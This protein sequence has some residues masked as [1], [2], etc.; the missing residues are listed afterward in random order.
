M[1]EFN[2]E[3]TQ[4]EKIDINFLLQMGLIKPIVPNQNQ[5]TNLDPKP[6]SNLDVIHTT[7][8]ENEKKEFSTLD[9]LKKETDQKRLKVLNNEISTI[10]LHPKNTNDQPKTVPIV[11]VSNKKFVPNTNQR[12]QNFEQ[13]TTSQLDLPSQKP[14]HI[15]RKTVPTLEQSLLPLRKDPPPNDSQWFQNLKQKEKKQEQEK[16]EKKI[17]KPKKFPR[18]SD[19]KVRGDK[20]LSEWPENDFR[21]FVGNLGKDVHEDQ[22][23][24]AFNKFPSFQKS[25]LIRDKVSGKPKFGFVSFLDPNDFIAAM[26]MHGEYIGSR[27]IILR[28]GKWK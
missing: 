21:I 2:Q 18:V 4:E 25:K 9:F 20:T 15:D 7:K 13:Y 8:K 3:T 10:N 28:K 14:S 24:E 26:Q 23:R 11:V 1:T 19:D 12:Q 16:K 27:P 22:L 17:K 6:E 5:K